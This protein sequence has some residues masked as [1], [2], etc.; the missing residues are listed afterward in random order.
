MRIELITIEQCQTD[1]HCVVMISVSTA[2]QFTT[3]NR[4]A[5]CLTWFWPWAL[6]RAWWTAMW[7]GWWLEK[8]ERPK[9][10]LAGWG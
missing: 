9:R 6:M 1:Y 7:H 3:V 4:K 10:K 2:A 5:E 8:T